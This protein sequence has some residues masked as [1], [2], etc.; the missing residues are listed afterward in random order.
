MSTASKSLDAKRQRQIVT[1]EGVPLGVT[2]ATRGS[3][4]IALILDVPQLVSLAQ[5]Q[6]ERLQ[7]AG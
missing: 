4:L 2:L 1:P 3:R 5:Q 7:A 6:E